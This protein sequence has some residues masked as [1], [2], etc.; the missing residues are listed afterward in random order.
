MRNIFTKI[1]YAAILSLGVT[2]AAANY[3]ATQGIGTAFFDYIV[4]S[5]HLPGFA[6]TDPGQGQSAAVVT[7]TPLAGSAGLEVVL[8]P[9]SAGLTTPGQK[10]SANS[11]SVVTASDASPRAVTQS[12]S[13]WVTGTGAGDPCQ[14]NAAT[15]TPISI[16]TGTTTKIV[17]GTAAKKL[18]ICYL[19]LQ[20]VNANNIAI[21]S[22]TTG[23]TCGANT[24]GLIGGTTATNGLNNPANGGQAIGNGGYAVAGV[25]TNNDDIC[26]IT[27]ASTPLAGVIK[28]VVQ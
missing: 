9:D 21:I 24:A 2:Y 27:S 16:T 19:Y 11:Q 20:T 12:T 4:G 26:L 18:Y 28:T 14:N 6:I 1:G 23:G 22:G 3:N 15:F 5:V 8:S 10:T 13:P 25:A 7:S 17:T